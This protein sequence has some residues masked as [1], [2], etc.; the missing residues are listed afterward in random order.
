MPE[1]MQTLTGATRREGYTMGVHRADEGFARFERGNW[2][3]GTVSRTLSLLGSQSAPSSRSSNRFLCFRLFR[4]GYLCLSLLSLWFRLQLSAARCGCVSSDTRAM[5]LKLMICAA[6]SNSSQMAAREEPPPP[7][8]T[9]QRPHVPCRVL[10]CAVNTSIKV[11]HSVSPQINRTSDHLPGQCDGL[12]GPVSS[13]RRG[14]PQQ[15]AKRHL[16]G[17]RACQEVRAQDFRLPFDAGE[18]SVFF[19]SQPSD[20]AA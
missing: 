19:Y 10:P 9:E 13:V 6:S 4:P 14:H 20:F 8:F 5:I 7:T 12:R 16:R 1:I 15:R 11:F 18:P 17:R 2:G 3:K